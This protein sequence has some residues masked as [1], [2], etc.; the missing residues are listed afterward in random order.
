MVAS[1]SDRA[2]LVIETNAVTSAFFNAN[3]PREASATYI[4]PMTQNVSRIGFP[5]QEAVFRTNHG[6]DPTIRAKFEPFSSAS[7][8]LHSR[9]S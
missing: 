1:A 7:S 2:A 8:L 3:D 4:D 5:L 6:Y 9:P